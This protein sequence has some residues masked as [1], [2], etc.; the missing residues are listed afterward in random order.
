MQ[1]IQTKALRTY[2]ENLTYFQENIPSLYNKMLALDTLLNEGTYPQK[3][4]LEYKDGYFDVVELASGAYLYKNDSNK[5]AQEQYSQVS[6]RKDDQVFESYKNLF[7]DKETIVFLKQ[8]SSFSNLA[9]IAPII[10]YYNQYIYKSTHMTQLNKFI[11]FGSGLGLHIDK[12]I[13]KYNVQVPW[14]IEDDVELFRLSLFVTNYKELSKNRDLFFA[15]G[16]ND[17]ELS[18]VFNIFFSKAFMKNL[19]IKFYLFSEKDKEKIPF[20]QSKLVARPE[21]AYSHNRLLVKN[22]KVIYKIKEDFKFLNLLKKEQEDFFQDKPLIILGAGP[23]LH[24]NIQWLKENADNF[25]IMAALVSLKTLKKAGISPDIVVQVDENEFTT[26][27]ILKN[28]GDTSFL[29]N[30]I[31]IFSASVAPI[32]FETFKKNPIY[33]HEDRTKYKLAKSTMSVASVG[34]TLYAIALVFNADNIYMLGIDLALGSDGLSHSPDHFMAQKLQTQNKKEPKEELGVSLSHSIIKVKGNFRDQVDTNPLLAMSIPIINYKTNEYKSPNQ[35]IYNL[36]DG[37][38]FFNTVAK[39]PEDVSFTTHFNKN[40]LKEELTL[41]FDKYSSV[42]LDTEEMDALQ[43]RQEHIA[44]SKKLLQEFK[45]SPY[46]NKDLFEINFIRL[47]N[48]LSNSKCKFELWEILITYSHRITPYIDDFLNTQEITNNKK[49]IKHLRT[50]IITQFGKII[51][52]YEEILQELMEKN[53]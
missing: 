52:D 46:S 30:T 35:T 27:Q 6:L 47:I 18:N 17:T 21:V 29:K 37:A 43:C 3:Y 42:N 33:L 28:L 26:Q 23:S 41:L 51:D 13:T 22:I 8:Q 7:F 50:L 4:D 19:Y 9:T 14:I 32:M 49:H 11:F 40:N 34:E 39:K 31:F 53:N 12:I 44:E 25:V 45:E 16:L 5:I 48:K 24:K 2:Q 1:D 38:F 10:D 15:V 20:I 36:S